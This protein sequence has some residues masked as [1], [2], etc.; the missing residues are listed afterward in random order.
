MSEL[1]VAEISEDTADN[2]KKFKF[3]KS[4][5]TVALI[6]KIDKEALKIE[7][8]QILEDIT[9]NNLKDSLPYHQPRYILLSY[10]YEKE[11]GRVAFPY[12]LLFSTPMG[13][14][15]NLKMMYTTSLTNLMHKSGVT[16][17][18]ELRDLEELSDEWLQEN[19][20]RTT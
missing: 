6:L 12:C 15:T 13:S 20:D 5:N 3:R 1:R 8:E 11:D 18:F 4:Q 10:R 7:P 19:L 14:A 2:L 9:L 17:V 16:K